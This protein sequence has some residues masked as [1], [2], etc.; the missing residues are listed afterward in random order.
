[1]AF[2]TFRPLRNSSI[3]HM[4][5]AGYRGFAHRVS[6]AVAGRTGGYWR[7]LLILKLFT[8]WISSGVRFFASDSNL[9]GSAWLALIEAGHR[10]FDEG[11]YSDAEQ[12]FRSALAEAEVSGTG[13]AELAATLNDLGEACRVQS[14]LAQAELLIG[15]GP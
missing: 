2:L 14:Q 4:L 3:S 9:A 15:G 13:P 7:L 1:M 5:I 8:R 11:R 12:Q 10:A 6:L